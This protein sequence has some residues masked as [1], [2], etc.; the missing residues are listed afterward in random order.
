[1][2][3]DRA[4]ARVSRPPGRLHGRM[5]V[6][7]VRRCGRAGT[8][9]NG[10]RPGLLAAMV[11]FVRTDAAIRAELAVD[12]PDVHRVVAAAFAC[13]PVVADLVD[14]L[15]AST[16]WRPGLSC[17][18]VQGDDVV[19]HVLATRGWLDAPRALVE[20][21]VLS[22]LSVRPDRQGRGIGTQLVGHLLAIAARRRNQRSSW[23]ARRT[24]TRASG[25]K[26]RRGRACDGHRCA[27]PGLRSRSSGCPP[28]S[29]RCRAHSSTPSHSGPSTA[30]AFAGR[31]D[32]SPAR[33][34]V[35]TTSTALSTPP[36]SGRSGVRDWRCQVWRGVLPRS[37]C[38]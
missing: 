25:S 27:S 19:G 6:Y 18:A 26:A 12:A 22:P 1:M 17:V 37:G 13:R 34:A 8:L 15:R 30:S 28:G 5:M 10:V 35:T 24:T 3:H 7:G 32:S 16:A 36:R 2:R 21:L 33:C 29:P 14:A 9:K 11:T 20:V 23:R 4:S 38:W 31:Y